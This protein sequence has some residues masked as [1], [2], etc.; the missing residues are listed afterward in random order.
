MSELQLYRARWVLPLTAP[1]LR[2]GLVAVRKG[3]VEALGDDLSAIPGAS[4]TPVTDCGE[5]VIL[6]GL[7]NAHTHLSLS[8]LPGEL[9]RGDWFAW[10]TAAVGAAAAL[11]PEEVAEGV[12][13]GVEESRRMGTVLLGEITTRP[14]GTGEIAA[15]GDLAARV[16]FEFLGLT[17]DRARETFTAACSGAEALAAAGHPG[18]RPGLAPHAPY[19]VRPGFWREAASWAVARDLPWSVH[20]AEPPG[21]DE[22]LRRGTGPLAGYLAGIRGPGEGFPTP[23]RTALE[24][25]AE[26]GALGPRCLLVHAVH[27]SPEDIRTVADSGSAIC[28]CPRSNARLGLPPAPVET[29]HRAGIPLCLGTDSRAGNDDLGVWGEM[30]AMRR[31]APSVPA[32]EILRMATVRGARALGFPEL[33]QGIRPGAPARLLAVNAE[34]LGDDNPLEFLLREPVEPR[35]SHL[36][37]L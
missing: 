15:G 18:I 11:T 33:A 5:A 7:V 26:A 24:L 19:S 31:L 27:L 23:G 10:M 3:R 9:P 25:L 30:R 21:E 22:F 13:R 32:E 14:E 28:L 36:L 6:P 4:G 1:P 29:L 37:H 17:A 35:I 16:F 2:D 8:A 34:G 20:L 12:R